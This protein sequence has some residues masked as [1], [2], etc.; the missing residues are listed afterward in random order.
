MGLKLGKLKHYKQD[1]A[2]A[3]NVFCGECSGNY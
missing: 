1:C 3:S 2:A